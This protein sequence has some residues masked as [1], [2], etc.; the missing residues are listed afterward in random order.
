MKSLGVYYGYV[1]MPRCGY[2]EH[3]LE[4]FSFCFQKHI[5]HL[6]A[7]PKPPLV[8]DGP[9]GVPTFLKF[10]YYLSILKTSTVQPLKFRNELASSPQAL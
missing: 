9:L 3:G 1:K 4:N 10:A 7:C 6:A 8:R 5:A 2:V